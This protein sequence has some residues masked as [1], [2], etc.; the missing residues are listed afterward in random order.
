MHLSNHIWMISPVINSYIG[1][2]FQ[3]TPGVDKEIP[4][5]KSSPDGLI[6]AIYYPHELSKIDTETEK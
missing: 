1:K 4:L 5:P 2:S 3:W 6:Y